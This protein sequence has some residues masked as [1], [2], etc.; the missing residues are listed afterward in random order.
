MIHVVYH[1]HCT[2]GFGSAW[3]A[4]QALGTDP[5]VVMYHPRAYGEKAPLMR[6][7]DTLYVFD[8]SFDRQVTLNLI[9][10]LDGNFWLYDHHK[11]AQQVLKGLPHCHFDMGKS[12][13]ML[14]W[15]CFYGPK[16]ESP[17]LLKYVQDWDL[18]SWKLPLSREVS[19]ALASYPQDFA[20]W[21]E[22]SGANG[23][24]GLQQDGVAIQRS[25]KALVARAVASARVYS[26]GVAWVPMVN[27]NLLQSEIG[28]ALLEEY[29]ETPFAVIYYE[30]DDDDTGEVRVHWSLRARQEEEVDVSE[31]AKV[32]G[33]GGH[34]S[35]AGFVTVRS[36]DYSPESVLGVYTFTND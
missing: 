12:G 6:P 7:W 10:H 23:L 1:A 3:A 5:A 26:L 14:A 29:P 34:K 13:A 21:D 36:P 25:N 2:D 18:W 20:V 24:V 8:Y 22:L 33:G 30:T 35:A 4:S 28:E 27:S 19:A 16:A 17:P 15:E 32:W 11:S 31:I 9:R